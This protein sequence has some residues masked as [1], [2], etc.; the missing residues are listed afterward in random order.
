MEYSTQV[1]TL[2]NASKQNHYFDN[3]ATTWPKPEQVYAFMDEFQR[4]Y[5]VNPGRGGYEM[6]VEAASMIGQT[7]KLL[8]QFFGFAGGSERVVFAH[9]AT[10]SLNTVLVGILSSGDHVITTRLE[11]N[12][13]LRPLNHLAQDLGV[14]VTH[15]RHN[16]DGYVDPD[17]VQRALIPQTCAIVVN[18]A[19]NVLGS[20]QDI[21]A[22][23]KIAR[24]AEVPFIV[25]T[26][27]T[28]G[29]VPINMESSLI[30]V[31]VFTGHK[32]LF[33]PMGTGGFI[34]REDINLRPSRYGGTGIN[35][36]E[37]Y[38][39]KTYPERLEVGTVA[40]PGIA[41]LNAAQRWFA[42]LGE[43]QLCTDSLGELSHSELSARAVKHIQAHEN[44]IINRLDKVFRSIDGV[45]VYGPKNG[46]SR[47][48]TLSLTIDGLVPEM[49][50]EVLDADYSVCTR[51]GLH[52]APLVHKDFGTLEQG[53]TVRFSPGYFTTD[54]DIEQ[55]IDGITAL[56]AIGASKRH[57]AK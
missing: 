24:D 28:A 4:S 5:A 35:S 53:G 2:G 6:G 13:V 40:V 39:P 44:Q 49:I 43:A 16:E 57:C 8:A 55:A 22:I 15:L 51:T 26:C 17:D 46:Q 56:A 30:D 33:G 11:H 41:G 21:T 18:H 42:A 27:Q 12:S 1:S 25:D 19:S 34:V 9:N 32:G 10:D 31:L 7:R 20:I 50:G 47:V 23:G 3:A 45:T 14:K 29:V 52:C 36:I 38:Q 37:R 48:P 54:V